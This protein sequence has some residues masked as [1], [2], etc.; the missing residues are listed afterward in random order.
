M[1]GTGLTPVAEEEAARPTRRSPARSLGL[2]VLVILAAVAGYFV[3]GRRPKA[4]EEGEGGLLASTALHE[5][6]AA[7]NVHAE[8]LEALLEPTPTIVSFAQNALGGASASAPF[9]KADAVVRALRARAS[10]AAFVP[11]SLA[12]PR[13][14]QVMT[15]AQTLDAIQKDGARLSLYP[16]ELAAL[17]VAALRALGVP[18]LVAELLR[19]EGERAPV[20]PS[21]FLGY[22]V[23]A[24]YP[25]EVGLGAP[26]LYDPYGGRA[27]LE[28]TKHQ[29]LRD[30]QAVGVA[31]ALRALH[32][33]LY[34]ADPKR[35]LASSAGALTLAGTLPSV[36]TARG[37]VVLA[38]RQLEQG[39]QEL[40]AA[41]QLRGDAPRLHNLASAELMT[42][43]VEQA[44]KHLDAALAE[45]PDLASAHATLGTLALLRGDS[46]QARSELSRAE[47]LAPDLSLVQWG[48]VELSLRGDKREQALRRAEAALA[49]RPSFDAHLRMGM[50]LR[51]LARYEPLREVASKLLAMAPDYRKGEV[52]E[53]IHTALG[54]TA[55]EG[56]PAPVADGGTADPEA[57]TDPTVP[58]LRDPTLP[59]SDG[60]KLRLL[61]K[62]RPGLHLDLPK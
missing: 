22:F 2:F 27:L 54:P 13:T 26:R 50:L 3:W 61:G 18:A 20:D 60:T 12:E 30:T 42:G 33:E 21:G 56:E 32:E 51:Q 52:R 4:G 55:L 57:A 7:A 25:G 28:G 45:S 59:D 5:A 49:A 37:M 34:L 35:A 8:S 62:Q 46:D 38:D 47:Q 39:L 41:R 48:L 58:A 1:R 10:T 53:L 19:V 17:G 29:V 15:A 36:R 9:P 14:T 11:W 44:Q 16:L 43:D 31:L 40:S 24:V 6:L 23:V